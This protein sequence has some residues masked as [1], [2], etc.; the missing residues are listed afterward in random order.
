MINWRAVFF[1]GVL[2]LLSLF[3]YATQESL[4]AKDTN[5]KFGEDEFLN[6][7]R[8]N[9]AKRVPDSFLVSMN[10]NGQEGSTEVFNT[11]QG[12][13][14]SNTNTDPDLRQESFSAED[15]EVSEQFP[16]ELNDGNSSTP[17]VS[18]FDP[19]N[20]GISPTVAPPPIPQ[21]EIPKA[22]TYTLPVV[23]QT[24]N[25]QVTTA[26]LNG[27]LGSV[28]PQM[29]QIL[30]NVQEKKKR[31]EVMQ[32]VRLNFVDTELGVVLKTLSSFLNKTFVISPKVESKV[33]IINPST[34]G[35]K[36]AFEVLLDTL[37]LSGFGVTQKDNVVKIFPKGEISEMSNLLIENSELALSNEL[38][39]RIITLNHMT[40]DEAMR[41]LRTFASNNTVKLVA[42]QIGN[43]LVVQGFS[44]HVERF[45]NILEKLDVDYLKEYKPHFIFL[46]YSK[47]SAVIQTIQKLYSVMGGQGGGAIPGGLPGQQG[48][49]IQVGAIK[50][51][52]ALEAE[53][54]VVLIAP[55]QEIGRIREYL[56]YLDRPI[57]ERKV[58]KAYQLSLAQVDSISLPLRRLLSSGESNSIPGASPGFSNQ[59]E[60]LFSSEEYLIMSDVRLNQVL[61]FAT[62]SL[63]SRV[64]Q[65]ISDLDR[66]AFSQ[67]QV[68]SIPVRFSNPEE[69]LEKL[70]QIYSDRMD[71][72]SAEKLRIVADN[73]RG[74]LILSCRSEHTLVEV[75]Q[76]IQQL[77]TDKTNALETEKLF[78]LENAK[79]ADIK[80]VVEGFFQKPGQGGTSQI[81]V[82]SDESSNSLLVK[83]TSSSLKRIQEIVRTLDQPV[84][85][86]MVEVLIIEALLDESSTL[87]VEWQ[88][89]EGSNTHATN[90]SLEKDG[91]GNTIFDN[92]QGFRQ[93]LLDPG[94]YKT[95]LQAIKA[96]EKV[97]IVATP[98][99][100]ASN[101]QE[102]SFLIGDQV[103][104][105][106]SE[107][108]NT[109]G[110]VNSFEYQDVGIKL[111]L[112]PR[113]LRD[114]TVS[115]EVSQEIK[116]LRG[117]GS[118]DTGGNPIIQTREVKTF[119]TVANKHTVVIGG[120]IREDVSNTRSKVPLMGD[121]PVVGNLFRKKAK[122][123][124]KTEMLIFLTPAIVSPGQSDHQEKFV[125]QQASLLD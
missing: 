82:V 108:Q 62:E 72:N 16:V 3:L 114:G 96:S 87:G 36:E 68:Q 102:A 30:A 17:L 25:V 60:I 122:T 54:A 51:M 39:T 116:T 85:Q 93:S 45:Q 94:R 66:K 107:S 95:F 118:A 48:E 33:T 42:D 28:P 57:H 123:S 41:I 73:Q 98:R 100:W 105:K 26:G 63:Q 70:K 88:W 61:V 44:S 13:F 81:T 50:S 8:M 111:N 6:E 21:F 104:I 89:T 110:T 55:P 65:M 11:V 47:A 77:D 103:P 97:K 79:A 71:Q 112:K 109:V 4:Q 86:I 15:N 101:N 99:L 92:L 40:P 91:S 37:E 46:Q 10:Q 27:N 34:L 29:A 119:A 84:E 31:E 76:M 19:A 9:E 125:N 14:E 106:T 56:E 20:Q 74:L 38:I 49:M 12:N 113:I 78:L 115:M 7:V 22:P 67:A 117:T 75:I 1:V 69:L 5:L 2:G 35:K 32:G 52:F 90:F 64:A 23:S 80:A 124:V 24:E 18:S 59:N 120:L 58:L 121:L 83:G 53:N 43:K